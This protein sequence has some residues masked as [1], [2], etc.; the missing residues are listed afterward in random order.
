MSIYNLNM[1][2]MNVAPP[3]PK[4]L[5]RDPNSQYDVNRRCGLWEGIMLYGWNTHFGISALKEKTPESS[6]TLSAMW[7]QN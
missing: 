5:C 1:T 3:Y 6:F 7:G 2:I 4:L